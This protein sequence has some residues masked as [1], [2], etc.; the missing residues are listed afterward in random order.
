MNQ[1]F[2]LP[3]AFLSLGLLMSAGYLFVLW[4]FC[5]ARRAPVVR[6]VCLKTEQPANVRR[7]S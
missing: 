2:F 6:P 5:Q 7:R 1:V 3:H 4:T